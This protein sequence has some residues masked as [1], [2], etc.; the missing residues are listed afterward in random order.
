MIVILGI[1]AIPEINPTTRAGTE[2]IMGVAV[3]SVAL[4]VMKILFDGSYPA[5]VD[6][7]IF[8]L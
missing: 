6:V 5:F 7:K 3:T 8:Y 2:R 4:A 1:L